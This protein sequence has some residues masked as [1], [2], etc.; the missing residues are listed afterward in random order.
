MIRASGVPSRD[1]P[2]IRELRVGRNGRAWADIPQWGSG[3]SLRLRWSRHRGRRRWTCGDGSS[4]W[5]TRFPGR[6]T[7]GVLGAR[8]GARRHA[9]PPPHIEHQERGT[10]ELAE[11]GQRDEPPKREQSRERQDHFR[12][13]AQRR[14][15]RHDP[16]A[17]RCR[18][19]CGGQTLRSR[20][21]GSEGSTSAAG[22]H[23]AE[24]R[25]RRPNRD[26]TA[27]PAVG[28]PRASH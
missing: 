27:P 6:W 13:R 26:F 1:R 15:H 2:E 12:E 14:R 5:T 11:P 21:R 18:P 3:A 22:Y 10:G 4:W 8:Q 9:H 16:V 25:R 28:F 19:N 7:K 20:A 23:A 24:T 17:P